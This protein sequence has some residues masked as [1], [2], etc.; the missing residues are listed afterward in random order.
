MSAHRLR[1]LARGLLA[2]MLLAVLA[3]A[4]SRALAS[5]GVAGDWVEVCSTEGMR[6]VQRTAAGAANEHGAP[7]AALHALDPCGH[8]ALAGERFAPLVPSP[9]SVPTGC[10]VW[11][12]PTHAGAT[13][14]VLGAPTPGA[15]G[16][17]LLS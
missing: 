12:P 16:P 10:A 3:P 7:D 11:A 17:P 4:V 15:R 6:W 9:L 8:C 2:A 13:V 1:W 5:T 14:H